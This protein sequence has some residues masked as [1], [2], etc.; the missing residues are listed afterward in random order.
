LALPP[1]SNP[2]FVR[3]VDEEL[4]RAELLRI[5]QRYGKWIIA[6]VVVIVLAVAIVLYLSHQSQSTAKRHGEDFDSAMMDLQE[7]QTGKAR[8]KFDALAKE[9]GPGYAAI[10]RLGEADAILAGG[11]VKAA[12]AKLGEVIA[13]PE[14][15]EP[16]RQ[17]AVVRQTYIEFDSLAPA[18]VIR[19]LRPIAVPDNPWF[20]TA[21]EMLATAYLKAGNRAEAGRLYGEIAASESVP[22]SIRQRVVELASML[23]SGAAAAEEAATADAPN[24]S[25]T[26]DNSSQ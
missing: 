1:D 17:M 25:Q 3:E 12:S 20:G 18:E 16:I 24:N 22:S 21:G 14:T 15:P 5:W 10:A 4:R 2:T 11:N 23:N 7:N 9:G 26:E 19:R 8:A 13:D 6:G